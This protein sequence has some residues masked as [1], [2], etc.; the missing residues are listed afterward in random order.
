MFRVRGSRFRVRCSGFAV[1][2][3]V[4]TLKPGSR[5]IGHFR[6][7]ACDVSKKA[8][9]E[10]CETGPLARDS[11][12]RKQIEQSSSRTTAHI[13]E[14]F[15]RFNPADFA[16]FCVIARSSLMESQ[17]HLIDLVDKICPKNAGFS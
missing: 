9:Y 1:A 12:R 11:G 10:L 13:A 7:Q 15:A 17:S 5:R 2:V 16:R 3:S 6:W 14:G 8:V 4:F